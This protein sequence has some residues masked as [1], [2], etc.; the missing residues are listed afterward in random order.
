[1]RLL[2]VRLQNIRSYLNGT[3][4]FPDG[5]VLLCGDIGCGKSTILLAIE[6]ALFG[7]MR[8]ALSGNAL[9]RNGKR[10]GSVELRMVIE[11]Q[12]VT[13]RRVLKRNGEEVVQSA[14]YIVKN[15]VKKDLTPVELKAEILNLLGY[16]KEL[17]T[18]SKNMVYRYTV[19]TPQE[20][21]KQIL[22]EEKEYRLDTLR[23]VFGIDKYKRTRENAQTY[24]HELK[25]RSSRLEGT[26]L[27][28]DDKRAR[29]DEIS[30]TLRKT[31]TKANELRPKFEEKQKQAKEQQKKLTELQQDVNKFK[32]IN[33]GIAMQNALLLQK[34]E[35]RE[36]T[37]NEL[38]ALGPHLSQLEDELRGLSKESVEEMQR[39]LA[40]KQAELSK[41]E[42]QLNACKALVT[43]LNVEIKNAAALQEKIAKMDECPVCLQKVSEGHKR[44]IH[45]REAE[46]AKSARKKLSDEQNQEEKLR[47]EHLRA[48]KELEELRAVLQAA[49][50]T[51]I[52]QSNLAEK[53][54]RLAELTEQQQ[55]LKK[56]VGE[57]NSAKIRLQAEVKRF[58]RAEELYE[59]AKKDFDSLAAEERNAA[60]ELTRVD[61][62]CRGLRQQTDALDKEIAEK[63]ATKQ[64]LS[65][66][67]KIQQWLDDFFVNLMTVMEKQVMGS[68]HSDFNDMFQLWFKMLIEDEMLSVRLDDEFTPIIEQNGYET[69]IENLSGGE[70]ASCALAYRLALNKVINDFMSTIKTRDV[71][72]LD[73]P[74]DGF[75]SEQLD[76]VRDVLHEL[77]L[78]QVIIVSHESKIEGFVDN[79]IRVR[80]EEHV[81]VI[82]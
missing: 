32:E 41:K 62:E 13:I 25:A 4:E 70:K 47:A 58:D 76:K 3:I 82:N 19:Y 26:I 61:A 24:L 44:D 18:K 9:L 35:Q 42:E 8:G 60:L 27:D 78:P 56:E 14:G 31:E 66:S 67:R 64:R 63:T 49:Q 1:M 12:E 48:N 20:E 54:A 46:K 69:E 17:L 53:K 71:L 40:E 72:I 79:I 38:A 29:R 45:S 33:Y 16:P 75:S 81:S 2:S 30:E 57:I 59:L 73:E 22:R 52:K 23:R 28:L 50:V 68:V 37:A 36:R 5:S 11:N 65:Q 77:N 7:I 51:R 80:K 15:D 43:E 74:T 39:R 10:D 34:V 21:M 55:T 6:F